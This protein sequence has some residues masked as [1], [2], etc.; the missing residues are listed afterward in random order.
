MQWAERRAG[1]QVVIDF[2]GGTKLWKAAL[3][4]PGVEEASLPF[5]SKLGDKAA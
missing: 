5:F 2:T 1:L 3:S 4:L